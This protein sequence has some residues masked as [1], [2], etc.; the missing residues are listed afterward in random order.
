MER[1]FFSKDTHIGAVH[2]NVNFMDNSVKFYHEILGMDIIEHTPTFSSLGVNDSVLIYLYQTN[3]AR[4]QT[5]GLFHFALLVP[6]RAV[7]GNIFYHLIKT[8]YPLAGASNHDVSEAIYLQDPEGNG[9]EI[10]RD[11][12]SNE[13]QFEPNGNIVMGTS[14][15]DY[16][17]VI[18][19]NH[20]RPFD[21]MP[22]DTIIGHMHL[23]V[24]DL[25]QSIAF[26]NELFGLDVM[27]RYGSQAAFMATAGY[28]HHL[29]LNTWQHQTERARLDY[30]GLRK[31]DLNIPN[32]E[33]LQHFLETLSEKGSTQLKDEN[34]N[35]VYD[36][37]GIGIRIMTKN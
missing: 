8:E 17:A 1:Q 26:Y 3:H 31:F 6:S 22:K 13:W 36:P 33:D 14:E 16:A 5:A 21:G 19:A 11:V 28:H 20:N 2:L 37:S 35:I 18:E 12:P 25:N 24:I 34:S 32:E 30:P 27:T 9:I 7:L 15:M 29:G 4:V 23:S 10:Y